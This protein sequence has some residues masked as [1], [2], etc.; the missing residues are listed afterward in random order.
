MKDDN[1]GCRACR[2]LFEQA[3]VPSVSCK[4]R[5]F[6]R[7]CWF[8]RGLRSV[9]ASRI[10][11]IL[12]EKIGKLSAKVELVGKSRGC[13]ELPGQVRESRFARE[14]EPMNVHRGDQPKPSQTKEC[15]DAVFVE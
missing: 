7:A 1:R 12:K 6:R 8:P 13:E 10:W 3:D 2:A 5:P 11:D 4:V 14:H 9:D 15:A